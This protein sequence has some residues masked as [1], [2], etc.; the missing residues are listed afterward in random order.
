MIKPFILL[1]AALAVTPHGNAADSYKFDFGAG[2]VAD[3]YTQVL[4]AMI[5]SEER[6]YGFEPGAQVESIEHDGNDALRGDFVTGAKPFLFSVA[7]PEGNYNVTVTFGDA[8]G[9][10]TN[11]V[12]AESRRLMLE[13]VRTTAGGFE[14]RTFTVNVRTPKISTGGEVRLKDREKPYLHWDNKLTIE[15]NGARPCVTALG[16]VRSTNAITV[17]LA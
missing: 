16:I 14:T 8:A 2:K 11:T 7:V 6:G 15:F 12:K 3:G 9:A 13:S 17:Y 10:S 4:P 5:Y 1:A